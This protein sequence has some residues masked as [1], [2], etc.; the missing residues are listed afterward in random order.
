[1]TTRRRRPTGGSSSSGSS[2]TPDTTTRR[3]TGGPGGDGVGVDTDRID[4]MAD[5]LGNTGGRV[6][7][8]GTTL[9]GIDVGPQSMGVVG[10]SFTG[11]AQAHVQTARQHVTR[12]R[13]A[14]DNAQAGTSSTARS[15]R[16]TEATNAENLGG[17]D[18]TTDVP[19]ARGDSTTTPSSSSDEGGGSNNPPPSRTDQPAS[20]PSTDSGGSG[21]Q[22]PSRRDAPP[23]DDDGG[24]GRDNRDDNRDD[25]RDENRDEDPLP[26]RPKDPNEPHPELTPEERA[27][28]D[29]HLA[30]LERDDPER[31]AELSKDPDH[32]GK[33]TKGSK[34]EARIAMDL[35]E[36]GEGPF[37]GD[38]RRPDGP[39]QGDFVDSDGKAQD[40]KGAHSDWPPEV[41]EHVRERPFPNAY[42][43]TDFRET[44]EGQFDR[45]RDVVVDTRNANQHDID[46]MRRIVEEEGWGGRIT[47]Y[48]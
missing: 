12:T 2:N 32:N 13:Q 37:A 25:G 18:T 26:R 4:T 16:D 35:H 43:E 46:E 21:N 33:V 7:N 45:G 5:R 39:G 22:P 1:M 27:A 28:L 30:Q 38:Y 11:A 29:R 44:V 3:P 47:W 42:N 19:T 8:V 24:D 23:S 14:V 9:D 40:M 36:R 48:P 6:D 34:D 31:F 17:I 15:Y 10:S 41:P 20:P